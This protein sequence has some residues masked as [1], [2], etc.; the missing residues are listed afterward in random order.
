MKTNDS[1]IT[2]NMTFSVI[3]LGLIGVGM[4][5]LAK[6]LDSL[7]QNLDIYFRTRFNWLLDR[8]KSSKELVI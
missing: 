7:E 2:N 3:V 6:I 4:Y 1:L 8:Q 5:V